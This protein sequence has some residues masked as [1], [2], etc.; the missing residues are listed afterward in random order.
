[1]KEL[2]IYSGDFSLHVRLPFVDGGIRAGFPIP[3]QDYIDRSIDFNREIIKNIPPR[4][5]M[6]R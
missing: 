2:E 4:L 6:P 1:M 5:S 3:A